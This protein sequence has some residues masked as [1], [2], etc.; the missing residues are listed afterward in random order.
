MCTIIIRKGG[1]YIKINNDI[2][3]TR[4]ECVYCNRWRH[5]GVHR[6][7]TGKSTSDES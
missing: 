2:I 6:E 5:D 7:D 3:T 4:H 1:I